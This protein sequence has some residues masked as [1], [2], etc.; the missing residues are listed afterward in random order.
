MKNTC[1]F[2]NFIVG[3]N[4]LFYFN[5][6]DVKSQFDELTDMFSE[7]QNQKIF[8][9]ILKRVCCYLIY[10]LLLNCL[11]NFVFF[12]NLKEYRNLFESPTTS[13]TSTNNSSD[14]DENNR[15]FIYKSNN[16]VD[17][18]TVSVCSIQLHILALLKKKNFHFVFF[19][20]LD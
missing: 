7:D 18:R 1:F 2:L 10:L 11:I 17:I 4:L 8:R 6:S 15:V 5:F 20:I 9:D 3:V 16:P 19:F 14:L 12:Q 13:S